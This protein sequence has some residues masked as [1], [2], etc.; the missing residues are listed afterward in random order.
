MPFSK[1]REVNPDSE[2]RDWLLVSS[3]AQNILREQKRA[4]RWGIFFKLLTF[5]YLLLLTIMI[6]SDGQQMGS[7]GIAKPHVGLIK[8]NG[9]IAADEVSNADTIITGLRQAFAND[10]SKAIMLSINSPGGSPVQ[11]GYIYDEIL[12]LRVEYPDKKL[13]AVISELGASGAY[14]IA[15]A[16]DEI[17][18]DKAS[19]V[20][21]I[22]V[23]AS[24][25]GYVDALKKLGVE[26]R[27]FVAGEHKTFL[28]PFS[29]LEE[30]EVSFW[31]AVLKKTHEQFIRVVKQGRGDRLAESDELFSG[32]VW[33]GEQA[34]A[35]GLIDGLGS[36]SY[37]ARQVIGTKEL[38]DYTPRQSP[39]EELTRKFGVAVGSGV[40]QAVGLSANNFQFHY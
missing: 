16:A 34:L 15:A 19:L 6:V 8:I 28:D 40:A 26:R 25:F 29:P 20:G 18:A 17:Y 9:V 21:S 1:N 23:T 31:N 39:V 38:H 30:D 24:G 5:S 13:Y 36:A 3:L 35:L 2:H 33:N 14:Y 11:A 37:V 7:V 32:L 27:H 4:R 10:N 22:G 12:R